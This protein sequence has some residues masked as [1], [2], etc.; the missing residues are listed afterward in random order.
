V[1]VNYQLVMAWNLVKETKGDVGAFGTAL[2]S[3]H[4]TVEKAA[5]A[6]L[7]AAAKVRVDNERNVFTSVYDLMHSALVGDNGEPIRREDVLHVLSDTINRSD[8]AEAHLT[9]HAVDHSSFASKYNAMQSH[10]EVPFLREKILTSSVFFALE[11]LDDFRAA[12]NAVDE[13]N[14]TD[15]EYIT[16]HAFIE[17]CCK[18]SEIL[19]C[20]KI[21]L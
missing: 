2:F 20:N 1:R 14:G 17:V 9:N 5:E 11:Q 6:K 19:R 21:R 16:K 18:L 13:G 15:P 8:E 10:T 4:P 7:A 3:G 12:F